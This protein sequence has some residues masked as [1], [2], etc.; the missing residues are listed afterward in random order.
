MS[1]RQF[2]KLLGVHMAEITLPIKPQPKMA[3]PTSFDARQQW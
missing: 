2:S 3:I 1:L